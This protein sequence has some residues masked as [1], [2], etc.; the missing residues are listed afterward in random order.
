MLGA[1]VPAEYPDYLRSDRVES[2]Y[3]FALVQEDSSQRLAQ[4]RLAREAQN[5]TLFI[6]AS[7]DDLAEIAEPFATVAVRFE[8]LFVE[9]NWALIALHETLTNDSALAAESF[10]S[11]RV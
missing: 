9:C 5:F 10:D 8:A 2:W 7:L 1:G 3:R 6:D 11:I 4:P